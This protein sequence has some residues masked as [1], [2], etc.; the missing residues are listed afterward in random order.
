MAGPFSVRNIILF[1]PL[2]LFAT[3]AF[4]QEGLIRGRLTDTAGHQVL[5][6]AL[7]TVSRVRDSIFVRRSLSKEDASFEISSLP[8]GDYFVRF[9]FQGFDPVQ[10]SAQL[11]NE[12]PML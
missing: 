5:K 7:I 12:H 6:G 10:R 8:Y 4:A 3:G 1:F 11:D 9:S 2:L